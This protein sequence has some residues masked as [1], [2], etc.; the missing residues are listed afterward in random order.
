M[1]RTFLKIALIMALAYPTV[2]F[3]A[4]GASG[5]QAG[6]NQ[7]THCTAAS[8]QSDIRGTQ[9][10][11]VQPSAARG[12]SDPGQQQSQNAAVVGGKP[13][14]GGAQPAANAPLTPCG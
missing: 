10:Q 6:A 5:S 8:K 9:V 1:K 7:S 2:A 11:G 3:G 14:L 13:A 4:T 12:N